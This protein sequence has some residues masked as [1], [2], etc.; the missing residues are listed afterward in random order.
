LGLFYCEYS[1]GGRG[2]GAWASFA[3]NTGRGGGGEL[4]PLLL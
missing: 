2:G 4:G 3:V 1:W